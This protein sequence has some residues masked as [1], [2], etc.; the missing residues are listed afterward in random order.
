MSTIS[1]AGIHSVDIN[2]PELG[3]IAEVVGYYAEGLRLGSV[4][5]L[6]KAFHPQAIMSGYFNGDLML[7]PMEGFHDLVRSVPAPV[8]SGEPFRHEIKNVQV[9][10]STATVEI[11]EYCFLGHDF[12]TCFH[13]I[14]VDSR[15]QIISKLFCTLGPAQQG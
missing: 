5:A 13:L 2:S 3:A 15:W 14:Q 7:M 1:A 12:K 4:E 10:G 11:T 8:N 6:Q 9:T